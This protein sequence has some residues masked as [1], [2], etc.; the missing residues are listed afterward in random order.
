MEADDTMAAAWTLPGADAARMRR[1][2]IGLAVLLVAVCAL[3]FFISNFRVYQLTLVLA[4]SI[5][6]LGLNMLTGYNGQISLGHGAFYA[7]G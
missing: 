5:A 6:L 4:Y 1:N 3:P 7:I 2:L